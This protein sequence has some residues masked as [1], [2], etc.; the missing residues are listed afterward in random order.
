MRGMSGQKDRAVLMSPLRRLISGIVIVGL[1]VS[2][3]G[4]ATLVV[5][6]D[7]NAPPGHGEQVQGKQVLPSQKPEGWPKTTGRVFGVLAATFLFFQFGLS[8]KPKPLDRLFGLHRVLHFHR[9]L[10]LSLVILASLHPLFMFASDTAGIG[11][12]RLAIWPKLLGILLLIGLWT[13]VCVALWR[14]FLAVPYQEW[15]LMHRFAMFGAVGIFTLHVWNVTD[16]FHRGWPLYG[17]VAAVLLYAALFAWKIILKPMSLK[18]QLYTV[19]KIDRVGRDTHAVELVPGEGEVFSYAPG[20]FAFVTFFSDALPVERHHWTLSSTPTKRKSCIFTIKCSGDF[21]SLVGRLKA[22]ERAAVDGPYGLFSYLAHRL[23]ADTELVMVAGGIGI[24]PML[25]MLRYM[26]DAGDHRKVTLVWS[27][28]SEGH[29]LCRKEL[30]GMTKEHP[31]LAIHHV[32]TRE[33]GFQRQ[34]GRLT[35]QTLKEL[36]AGCD[37]GSAVFVCG[38]PPMMDEVSRNMR[39]LGFKGSHIYK[40]K[41]SY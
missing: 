37:R 15:Y 39:G 29:I 12:L 4:A 28:R 18:K 35:M 40:E 8:S 31:G 6:E 10:G 33:K 2:V 41:F 36:L 30:E 32:L 16:D 27:N 25:S 5:F 38:P 24:T 13:G 7:R 11:P 23:D 20:Q 22:G 21:T 9:I 17:L 14:R 26:A 1:A 3:L 34:T 19:T